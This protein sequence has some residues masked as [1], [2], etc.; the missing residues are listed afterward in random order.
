MRSYGSTGL[1]GSFSV[2]Y[3][4]GFMRVVCWV[5]KTDILQK[6]SEGTAVKIVS[7]MMRE[8]QRGYK[9]VHLNDTS[10]VIVDP[11][12][13]IPDVKKTERKSLKDLTEEDTNVEILG[14]IVQVFDPYFFEVCPQC[15]SRVKKENEVLA[16]KT[17]GE[18]TPDY[19]YVVN[20]YIDDGSETM[21]VVLFRAQAEKLLN[22]SKDAILT[23]KD[24]PELFDPIKTDL[25]GE[26]FRFVGRVKKNTFFDRLEFTANQLFPVGEEKIEKDK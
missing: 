18:V 12:E 14:T 8:N 7:G 3:D 5:S 19:S 2:V 6:L 1:V 16:C 15:N 21:R 17:H 10:K 11:E 13:K 4:I 25:L 22:K 20:V 26:Q 24:A 23:F 9:E